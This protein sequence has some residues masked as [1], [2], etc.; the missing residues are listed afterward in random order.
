[1]RTP[2]T[3]TFCLMCNTQV[4]DLEGNQ[5]GDKGLEAL[6]ASLATGALASL[7]YINLDNARHPQLMAACQAR[8]I[9]Q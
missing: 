8:G 2:L 6:S 9:R 7:Q 4:L 3:Q 5:I 1:M